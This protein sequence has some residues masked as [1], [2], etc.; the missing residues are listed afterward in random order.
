MTVA[1][2]AEQLLEVVQNRRERA[3]EPG[4]EENV[5]YPALTLLLLAL[6]QLNLDWLILHSRLPLYYIL[7]PQ[8]CSI[9]HSDW[10]ISQV[11][12][13]S[14]LTTQ[15]LLQRMLHQGF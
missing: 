2:A 1:Q 5:G 13:V 3:E 11:V 10:F 9:L 4:E 8:R 7:T 12:L 14:I 6:V 15:G